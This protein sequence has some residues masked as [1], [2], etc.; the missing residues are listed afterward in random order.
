MNS[1]TIKD[2]EIERVMDFVCAL[3]LSVEGAEQLRDSPFVTDRKVIAEN[4]R[5]IEDL[6]L[7]P[8]YNDLPLSSFPDISQIV[9]HLC[10]IHRSIDGT[11]LFILGQYLHSSIELYE[12]LHA[13]KR[14]IAAASNSTAEYPSCALM[15]RIPESLTALMK[16]IDFCLESPGVVKMSHPGIASLVH[17]L[18][19]KRTQRKSYSE[20]FL[21]EHKDTAAQS[22]PTYKDQRVVLPVRN[23]RRSEVKGFINSTSNS[24]STVFME[25]FPLVEY[26]NQ[27]V[28]LQ[29]KIEIEMAKIISS[30]SDMAFS[31]LS[32]IEDLRSAVGYADAMLSRSLFKGRYMCTFPDISEDRTIKLLEARHPLLKDQAVPITMEISP[33]VS[34]V[35]ISGPN[36]GGKTVSIKTVALLAFMHQTLF[37]IPAKEGSSLPLFSSIYT[38]VGD[39]QS[40]EKSLS[41]FS[42]HMKRIAEIV[43]SIDDRSLVILDELGSGTDPIEGAALAKA[44]VEHLM[45]SGVITLI[46]SHHTLLKQYAYAH[47][48]VLNASMEFDEKTHNPTFRVIS[49]LP[50]ESHA[51]DTARRM[52]LPESVLETAISHIGSQNMKVS[53]II[54]SLEQKEHQAERK[55]EKIAERERELTEM[56]RAYDLRQLSLNQK[57]RQVR[58]QQI[59][60]LSRFISEKRKELEN[61]V[62]ELREG[63]ITR[64]KTRK[65]KQY[66]D[67]LDQKKAES[68]DA[69]NAIRVN[70]AKNSTKELDRTLEVGMN[71]YAGDKKKEGV[72]V[73]KEKRGRYLVSIGG[74]KFTFR[75]EELRPK[76][77]PEKT[78]APTISYSSSIEQVRMSIDVRGRTLEDALAA[79]DT[80]IEGALLHGMKTFSIIHG[81]GDGILMRG[82]HERLSTLPYVSSFYF[83]RPEDGGH[84]KTYVEM[85][86]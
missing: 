11:E 63:E 70:P 77:M 35:V 36:A 27:V 60:S 45:D 84:G 46:T 6:S 28:L 53:T 10:S 32:D 67:S 13:P 57:E 41:T 15:D 80:Q 69:A 16:E 26:N 29:Q 51:I 31:A 38:D 68:R 20:S 64:E 72:I 42:S 1:N 78:K 21:K 24:G 33:P 65:V 25:S 9:G 59:G 79:V 62:A 43:K 19:S 73:R 76:G 44:I 8:L 22:V 49:G 34:T 14:D 74:M 83:A 52:G 3:T 50:G 7:I 5:I 18:E 37:V 56:K 55:L 40:I 4:Q 75:S 12:Y 39:E 85:G 54:S 48:H 71:V 17:A 81:M 30:L 47:Q 58:E 66:L 82:I 86:P 2:L 61:L 23:D